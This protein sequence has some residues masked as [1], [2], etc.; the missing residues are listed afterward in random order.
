ML[1]LQKSLNSFNNNRITSVLRKGEAFRQAQYVFF[2][3]KVGYDQLATKMTWT[4]KSSCNFKMCWFNKGL[5]IVS[6]LFRIDPSPV[7]FWL[8]KPGNDFLQYL[9]YRSFLC[10]SIP[11]LHATPLDFIITGINCPK[12]KTVLETEFNLDNSDFICKRFT[13]T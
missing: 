2:Q 3:R 1:I 9:Q 10:L 4:F 5:G 8:H 12:S 6:T 13:A 11:I 7:E